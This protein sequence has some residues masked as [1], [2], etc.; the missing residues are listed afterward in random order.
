MG[1]LASPSI[2]ADISLQPVIIAA[3][4]GHQVAEAWIERPRVFQSPSTNALSH[5]AIDGGVDRGVAAAIRED[6]A[7]TQTAT[8][9]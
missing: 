3:A 8:D 1:L 5:V 7:G 6:V 9:P 2:A 4:E